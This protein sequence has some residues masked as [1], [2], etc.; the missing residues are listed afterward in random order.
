VKHEKALI[1]EDG[2]MNYLDLERMAYYVHKDSYLKALRSHT[3]DLKRDL[4][5]RDT[6]QLVTSAGAA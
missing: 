2:G 6:E 4:P 5:T 1:R 3:A